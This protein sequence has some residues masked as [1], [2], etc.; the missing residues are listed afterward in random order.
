MQDRD[1]IMLRNDRVLNLRQ[2]LQEI[3][4]HAEELK[5]HSNRVQTY[6]SELQQSDFN[7]SMRHFL[8]GI[9]H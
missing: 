7:R 1:N 4:E 2:A 8:D 3:L 5:H 9:I 6:T